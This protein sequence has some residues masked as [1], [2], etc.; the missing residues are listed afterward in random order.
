MV[1]VL[2]IALLTIILLSICLMIFSRASYI[3][4]HH[5]IRRRGILPSGRKPAIE[6]VKNL[7]LRG[8]RVS[9]VEAY[10][11]I[12]KLTQRQAELEV[13]LLERNLQ[14]NKKDGL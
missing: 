9:A 11:R 13:D 8:E 12:Y 2:L 5:R 1:R 10:R 7:L 3:W 14:K 6:D 4:V